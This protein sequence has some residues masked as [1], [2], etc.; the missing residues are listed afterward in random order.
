MTVVDATPQRIRSIDEVV[1]ELK[2]QLEH[3]RPTDRRRLKLAAQLTVLEDRIANQPA[4]HSSPA[5]P[6]ARAML[7]DTDLARPSSP[8]RVSR[9]I[10]LPLCRRYRTLA[11]AL[12][13]VVNLQSNHKPPL[14]RSRSPQR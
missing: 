9:G 11:T 8:A 10:W 6:A 4:D 14:R 7:R 2:A 13:V 1:A 3:L 5:V 12:S